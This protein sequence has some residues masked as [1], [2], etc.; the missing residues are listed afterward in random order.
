MIK[1]HEH[2]RNLGYKP[3]HD[4]E[5]ELG[6][7]LKDLMKYEERILEKKEVLIPYIRWD[8]ARRKD[9]YLKRKEEK[10]LDGVIDS[11]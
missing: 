7:M 6:L 3:T 10:A 8:G 5:Q 11:K 1:D 4:V 9:G 2:I